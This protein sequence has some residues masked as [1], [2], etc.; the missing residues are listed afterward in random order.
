VAQIVLDIGG[1]ADCAP[2]YSW[3]ALAWTAALNAAMS[4]CCSDL[5]KS[6]R[7]GSKA[8]PISLR[9]VIQ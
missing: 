2:E 1:A 5:E 8:R 7:K 6:V 3:T 9:K 4:Q